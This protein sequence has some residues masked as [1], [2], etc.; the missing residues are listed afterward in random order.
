M[1]S[2]QSPLDSKTS[3]MKIGAQRVSRTDN[4][5]ATSNKSEAKIFQAE[6]AEA[7]HCQSN[8]T[9]KFFFYQSHPLMFLLGR[10]LR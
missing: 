4:S 9:D 1:F 3:S 8:G 7:E 5:S 6:R 2:S 10:F